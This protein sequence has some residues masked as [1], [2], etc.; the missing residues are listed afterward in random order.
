MITQRGFPLTLF[1]RVNDVV[2]IVVTHA[3]TQGVHNLVQPDAGLGRRERSQ[4]NIRAVRRFKKRIFHDIN[5]S[6]TSSMMMFAF[7]TSTPALVITS[8]YSLG[9]DTTFWFSDS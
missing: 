4:H 3:P 8:K 1:H 6:M 7:V 5:I 2:R 9:S